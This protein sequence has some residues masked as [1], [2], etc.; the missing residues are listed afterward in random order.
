MELTIARLVMD[1]GQ[2]PVSDVLPSP[3][4][5]LFGARIEP[6]A[7]YECF[8]LEPSCPK[9]VFYEMPLNLV[10]LFKYG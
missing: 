7:L 1:L 9:T 3:P 6:K 8:T 4:S 10:L 2:R 5:F